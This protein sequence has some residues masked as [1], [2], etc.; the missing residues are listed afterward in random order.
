MILD[1]YSL[2]IEERKSIC[3]K[4][5]YYRSVRTCPV[6]QKFYEAWVW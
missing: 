1:M 4:N 5:I 6:E 2:L 3:P